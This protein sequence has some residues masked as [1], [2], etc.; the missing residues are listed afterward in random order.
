MRDFTDTWQDPGLERSSGV[1]EGEPK[2][3]KWKS[4]GATD[5]REE[6]EENA[7]LTGE[8]NWAFQNLDITEF[9]KK[10]HIRRDLDAQF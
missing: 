5:E 1:G 7:V 3:C 2:A 10:H 8:V 9:Q 6:L 4:D